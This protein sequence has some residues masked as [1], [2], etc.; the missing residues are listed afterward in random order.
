[1]TQGPIIVTGVVGR[2]GQMACRV[3][4]RTRPVVGIDRRDFPTRPKDVVHHRIDLRRKKT[5][6]VFRSVKPSAV[7]HLGTLHDPRATDK[8]RHKWNVVAFQK[9]LEYV[10][11][12]Q[13]ATDLGAAEAAWLARAN[14]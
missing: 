5:R 12:G 8:E 2:L 7:L 14:S 10:A 3:L 1:M 6:D 11:D 9:L 4:H 13:P